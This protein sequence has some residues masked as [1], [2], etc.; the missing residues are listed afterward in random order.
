[1]LRNSFFI[2]N[3]IVSWSSAENGGES[4]QVFM[5]ANPIEVLFG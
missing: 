2:A 5:S 1:M 3:C 4:P